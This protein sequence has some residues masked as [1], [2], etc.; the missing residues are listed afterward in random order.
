MRR[1]LRRAAAAGYATATMA[2]TAF[3]TVVL[4]HLAHR[5][6]AAPSGR[7]LVLLAIAGAFG[8]G[9][10]LAGYRRL[11]RAGLNA[12]I[13]A[14]CA[15]AVLALLTPALLGLLLY[16]S[17]PLQAWL[18]DRPVA[19]CLAWA[20]AHLA[21]VAAA[22]LAGRAVARWLHDSPSGPGPVPT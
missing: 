15:L 20:A 9:Y 6:S 11:S 17:A 8:A 2:V 19:L 21:A 1:L 10:G 13:A 5:E 18:G 4:T 3:P 14:T 16:Q 12:W 22:E 7:E